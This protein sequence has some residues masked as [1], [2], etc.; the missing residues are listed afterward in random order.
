MIDQSIYG[1][2]SRERKKQTDRQRET[3]RRTDG[4]TEGREG[5]RE[6]EAVPL[7]LGR[8]FWENLKGLQ[9][10]PRKMTQHDSKFAY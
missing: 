1:E 5:G 10:L 6:K 3:D 7:E 4:Q 8:L 9:V 2:R